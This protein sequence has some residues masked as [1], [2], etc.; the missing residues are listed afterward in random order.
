MVPAGAVACVKPRVSAVCLFVTKCFFFPLLFSPQGDF[1]VMGHVEEKNDRQVDPL[2]NTLLHFNATA[3]LS[4]LMCNLKA[5]S[6]FETFI[7]KKSD[8][9]P[10]I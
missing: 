3:Y 10:D 9:G 6:R 2:R 4:L 5:K 8:S 7:R 1:A